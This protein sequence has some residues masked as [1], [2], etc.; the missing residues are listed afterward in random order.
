MNIT[1]TLNGNETVVDAKPDEKL[2]DVLRKNHIYSV[3]NGCGC[4]RCGSCTVLLDG[5]PV[6]SC[7]IP[8]GIVMNS[9]IQTLESFEKEDI[10]KDIAKGFRQ[11][12][13]QLC[14]YCNSSKFFSVYDFIK[15][16]SRPTQEQL[17][18]FIDDIFDACN[19]TE[20]ET[21]MTGV[22]YA[23]ALKLEREGKK[24]NAAK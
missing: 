9:K 10:Y 13:V 8:V 5:K 4:G 14:G 19:C 16:I 2:I 17:Q 18:E 23:A 24:K 1:F 15:K 6:K 21:L 22:L 7:L 20:R 11:A 12:G 3:K